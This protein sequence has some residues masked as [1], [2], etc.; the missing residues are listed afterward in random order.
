MITL[1][2]AICREFLDMGINVAIGTDSPMSGG[3]NLL[4]EMKYDKILYEDI[5]GEEL[6]DETIFT[7]PENHMAWCSFW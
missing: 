5:Y 3:L 1:I 6:R 4:H 7:E 2:E